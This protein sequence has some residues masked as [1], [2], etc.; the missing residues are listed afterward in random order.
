GLRTMMDGGNAVDAMLATSA[1]LHVTSPFVNGMGGDLFALIYEAKS[2]KVY[3]FNG[4]GRAPAAL[5]IDHV[6]GQGHER[7]PRRGP[8]SISVPGCVDAWSQIHGRFGTI[9][10]ADLIRPAISY[11]REGH[12]AGRNFVS[13][14]AAGI[15]RFSPS[16]LATFAPNGKG[17]V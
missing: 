5:T 12:P 15:P 10:W 8:L 6:R 13:G 9:A 17:P 1:S 4:S 14:V 2:G 7:M 16:W 11:A 3:G